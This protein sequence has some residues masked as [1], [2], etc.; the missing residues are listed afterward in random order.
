MRERFAI[1]DFNSG[2]INRADAE[3]ILENT[4]IDSNNIDGDAPE[5][6]LQAIP[7]ALTKPNSNNL[8]QASR[9]FE[10]IKTKDTKWHL[11][12]VD[13]A[14]INVMADFY[15]ATAP[16]AGI[17]PVACVATSMVAHNEEVHV[18]VGTATLGAYIPKLDRVLRLW[19]IRRSNFR[20]E[21]FGDIRYF[22]CVFNETN[23]NIRLLSWFNWT[24][25]NTSGSNAFLS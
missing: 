6:Q 20:V 3:D 2:I 8:A 19:T 12:H 9:L 5:G 13:S 22:V 23:I 7:I 10:W 4:A 16:T 15:H 1:T 17:T 21:I 25:S 11:V 24:Y 14:N 18:A